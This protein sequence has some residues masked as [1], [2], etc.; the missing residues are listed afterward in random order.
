MKAKEIIWFIVS[1]VI[2]QSAGLIGSLFT[3]PSIPTWYAGLQKPPFN[4][5]NVVFAPVWTVL[6]FLMGVSLFLVWRFGFEKRV[7]KVSLILFFS[8]LVLNILWSVL[9][10]GL[11]QPML[12]FIEIVILWIFILLTIIYFF[13]VSRT[14]SILMIPYILW[15]SFASILNFFIWRL[16]P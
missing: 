5:P 10:F 13:K 16:N 12:A 9:F 4:P 11:K 8:Q 2:C 1:I 7:V 3:T 14:A 6:F 15:V